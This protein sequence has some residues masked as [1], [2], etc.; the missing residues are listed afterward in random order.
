MIVSSVR[1]TTRV[2]KTNKPPV[3]TPDLVPA[4]PEQQYATNGA[5]L[6]DL[7]IPGWY[8]RSNRRRLNIG[9][10]ERCVL[11]QLHGGK[12]SYGAQ[13]LG[14]RIGESFGLGF[15]TSRIGTVATL[16]GLWTPSVRRLN[17]AWLA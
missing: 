5:T 10:P 14:L 7:T 9:H 13:R 2:R 12:W 3:R 11:A 6:L 1:S 8:R 17:Q 15:N 16:L 4:F